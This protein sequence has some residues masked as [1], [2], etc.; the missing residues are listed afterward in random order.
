[1]NSLSLKYKETKLGMT[2]KKS[3]FNFQKLTHMKFMAHI[4]AM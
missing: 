3:F 2:Y 1:M 4:D